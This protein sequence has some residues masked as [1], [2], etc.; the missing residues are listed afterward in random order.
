M[1]A[2]IVVAIVAGAF[3][4]LGTVIT[5]LVG[6]RKASTEI[7]EKT[8]LTL[9]RISE[10]EK[11]QDLHNGVIARVYELEGNVKELQHEVKDLKGFHGIGKNN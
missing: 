5:V 8:D 11:K 9:Y 1:S 6:N 10:L 7:K 3:T 2:E 4:F